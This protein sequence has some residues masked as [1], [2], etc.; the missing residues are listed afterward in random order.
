MN[1]F[2]DYLVKKRNLFG[3]EE[4][5]GLLPARKSCRTERPS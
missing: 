5:G 1:D 3:A 2:T 4:G